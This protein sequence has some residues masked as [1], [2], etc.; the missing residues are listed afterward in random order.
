MTVV[1]PPA[2]SGAAPSP[3]APARPFRPS[4]I[5]WIP[6]VVLGAALAY[7]VLILPLS[8]PGID[9]PAVYR[10]ISRQVK[11]PIITGLPFGH[12]DPVVTLPHGARIS[13]AVERGTCYLVM[14]HRH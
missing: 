10:W 13:L 5:G 2:A 8:R 9:L 3:D 7:V 4:A 1:A 12:A 6:R 11:A 14:P